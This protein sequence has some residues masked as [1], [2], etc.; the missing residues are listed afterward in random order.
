MIDDG[1]TLFGGRVRVLGVPRFEDARGSLWSVDFRALGFAP[2]RSFVVSA[3]SGAVR[4]EH[5][6]VTGRQLLF[7][8]GGEIRVDLSHAGEEHSVTLTADRPA[9]LVSSPVWARQTYLGE[10]P[11]LAVH[12]D[13]PYDPDTYLQTPAGSERA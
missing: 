8:T 9:M 7:R 1:E 4:G 13:A 6:H 5:G 3:P 12:C 11:A 2:V 10:A